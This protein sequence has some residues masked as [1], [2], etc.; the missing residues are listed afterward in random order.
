MIASLVKVAVAGQL[1]RAAD[2]A[3]VL[4]GMNRTLSGKLKGQFVTAA[5]LFV[6]SGAGLVRF[7]SAGHPPLL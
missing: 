2:P 7:A 5:Y 1:A 4:A 6:D 3:A